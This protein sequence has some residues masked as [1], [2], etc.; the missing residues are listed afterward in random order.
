MANYINFFAYDELI[1]PEVFKKH[2]FEANGQFSTTLSA[3][4]MV[5]NKI[6]KDPDN[7][8]PGVGLPNIVPTDSNI[9]M[10]EGVLYEMDEKFLPLLNAHYGHP[11]E[12]QRQKMRFTKHDFTNVGGF[13]YIAQVEKTDPQLLPCQEQLDKFRAAKKNFSK[14]YFARLVTQATVEEPNKRRP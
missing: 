1:I 11:E 4:K 13:T 3:H 5:F 8:K 7:Y 9:G 10:M 14:L 12:Y 2:G 6:P